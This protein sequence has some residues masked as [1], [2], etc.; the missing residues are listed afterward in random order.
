MALK[1]ERKEQFPDFAEKQK[2][3]QDILLERLD[4]WYIAKIRSCM[5]VREMIEV[6]DQEFGTLSKIGLLGK[7]N[8][9]FTFCFQDGRDFVNT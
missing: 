7:R 1:Q 4:F 8:Q 6:L 5:L 9:Y 2:I 3:A